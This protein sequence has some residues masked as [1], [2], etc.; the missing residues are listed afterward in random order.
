MQLI[1]PR[2]AAFGRNGSSRLRH[3]G[4]RGFHRP[5]HICLW[6]ALCLVGQRK[7]LGYGALV[8]HRKSADRGLDVGLLQLL[9]NSSERIAATAGYR[10]PGVVRIVPFAQLRL[11][12]GR[13][14]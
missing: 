2:A 1:G 8:Y 5:A 6:L 3:I 7:F 12:P 11:T 13:L 10:Y 14:A 4:H 9:A